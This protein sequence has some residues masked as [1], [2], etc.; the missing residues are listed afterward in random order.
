MK[1]ASTNPDDL[2]FELDVNALTY[3]RS[4]PTP[5]QAYLADIMSAGMRLQQSGGTRL[6]DKAIMPKRILK[7]SFGKHIYV[8]EEHSMCLFFI[9]LI[10]SKL[11]LEKYA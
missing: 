3:F 2:E 1:N 6:T 4:H 5:K 11:F 9:N 7:E 8:L 10:N